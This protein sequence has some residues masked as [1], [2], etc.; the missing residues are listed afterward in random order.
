MPIP[1]EAL[2]APVA[3]VADDSQRQAVANKWAT[4][5]ARNSANAATDLNKLKESG[6]EVQDAEDALK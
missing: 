3:A 6:F 2:D 1:E 5:K 4:A